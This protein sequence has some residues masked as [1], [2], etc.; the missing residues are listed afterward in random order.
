VVPGH[1]LDS[2]FVKSCTKRYP[3]RPLGLHVNV[4]G[5]IFFYIGVPARPVVVGMSAFA[6][7]VKATNKAILV[8]RDWKCRPP[9]SREQRPRVQMK[10]LS[11]ALL[12]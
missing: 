9:I 5:L 10:L 12:L 6:I 3:L 7:H 1:V 2:F 11:R 8:P 4:F